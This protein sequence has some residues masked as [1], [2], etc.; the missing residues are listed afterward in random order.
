M[1]R[2]A[3]HTA[4]VEAHIP[5]G[6][7]WIEGVHEPSPTPTDFL[8]VRRGPDGGWET[9]AF[10]RGA[11]DVLTRHPT[12]PPPAATCWNSSC[13][14]P[15]PAFCRTGKEACPPGRPGRMIGI[16]RPGHLD[17]PPAER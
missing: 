17:R 2:R 12:R 5:G 10:E 6:Y 8:F 3:L 9:G 1:D 14:R 7:Y 16:G 11:Y 15:S 4:L 13:E